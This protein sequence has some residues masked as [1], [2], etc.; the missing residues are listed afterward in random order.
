MIIIDMT[1][2]FKKQYPNIDSYD[3]V[4]QNS[5]GMIVDR[6]VSETASSI[7]DISPYS[8]GNFGG[9]FERMHDVNK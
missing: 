7:G 5:I 3:P 4:S 1:N 2:E 8:G 9:S 6:S